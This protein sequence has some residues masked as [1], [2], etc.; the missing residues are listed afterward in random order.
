MHKLK[1]LQLKYVK[2]RG[3][4]KNFPELRFLC[5]HGCHMKT[6]PSGLLMSSFLVAID[7]TNGN[8]QNF[9]PPMVRNKL[10]VYQLI[11]LA[12]IFFTV[13]ITVLYHIL[14][15]FL[16]EQVLTS[17]KILNLRACYKLISIRGLSR[18]PNLE[19]LILWDCRSLNHV[20]KTIKDLERLSL[21]NLAYCEKLCLYPRNKRFKAWCIGNGVRKPLFTLPRSLTFLFLDHCNLEYHN[22]LND[23]FNGELLGMSL[24]G[25][26]FELMP[27]NIGLNMLR[28]LNL[29][30]SINLKHI[31]HLP[32]TLNELCT[33]KCKSLEEI[34]F[35]SARFRLRKFNYGGCFNLTN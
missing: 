4:Y 1:L 18:L 22:D 31:R 32:S 24:A 3:S 19:T 6:I 26:T 21:L 13:L 27:R 30:F 33:Y 23:L 14:N 34:T 9:E 11:S 5:W 10:S 20:C 12:S 25:S 28:V 17:L 15:L 8:L 35:E 16:L 29:S 2:L 7:I